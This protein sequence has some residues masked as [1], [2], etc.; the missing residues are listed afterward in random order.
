MEISH[1][2]EIPRFGIVTSAIRRRIIRDWIDERSTDLNDDRS[3]VITQAA[4]TGNL[5]TLK[6]LRAFGNL[7]TTEDANAAAKHGH[8][9]VLK[10][11]YR[12]GIHADAR[13][14]NAAIRFVYPDI[15]VWF[16]FIG[17]HPDPQLATELADSE[18]LA[19][20]LENLKMLYSIG[21]IASRQGATEAL[22]S[23]RTNVVEWLASIG[24][25]PTSEA[26][27]FKAM[28]GDLEWLK[29]LRSIG[30]QPDT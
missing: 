3:D 15:I 20:K 19:G 25:K 27:N 10:W 6:R 30:V 8:L 18:A 28:I 16:D 9:D 12:I 22:L 11:M 1:V 4:Q 23:G 24:V 29:W 21:I 17:L 26:A 7:P 14:M 2:I 13:G 5:F